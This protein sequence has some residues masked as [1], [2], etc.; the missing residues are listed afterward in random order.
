MRKKSIFRKVHTINCEVV[1]APMYKLKFDVRGYSEL[2]YF[3]KVEKPLVAEDNKKHTILISDKYKWL[4]VY[5]LHENWVLTAIYDDKNNLVEWYYDIS[6]YNFIDE[7]GVPCL[8]EIYLNLVLFPDGKKVMVHKDKLD[9]ALINDHITKSDYNLAYEVYNG[10]CDSK[11]TSK[12]F[13]YKYCDE[14]IKSFYSE[15]FKN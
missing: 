12:E 6:G 14:I 5:P 3:N 9:N 1:K 4:I 11:W 7:S 10:L 2:L 8:D 15:Y 13:L